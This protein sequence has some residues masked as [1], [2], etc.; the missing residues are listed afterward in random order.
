M[1]I[2]ANIGIYS[3]YASKKDHKVVAIERDVILPY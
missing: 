1:D 2:G 3:L